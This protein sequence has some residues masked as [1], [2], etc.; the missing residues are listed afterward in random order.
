LWRMVSLLNFSFGARSFSFASC[1]LLNIVFMFDS[2][3][4]AL[5]AVMQCDC[6]ARRIQNF[7]HELRQPSCARP[8]V[9]YQYLN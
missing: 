8:V 7:F 2:K 5:T 9:P 1:L 3:L 6:K 4:M